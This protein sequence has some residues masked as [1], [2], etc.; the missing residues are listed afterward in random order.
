MSVY[1]SV[2]CHLLQSRT[3]TRKEANSTRDA[4]QVR[5]IPRYKQHSMVTGHVYR[6]EN[7]L[8]GS[9]ACVFSSSLVQTHPCYFD[10]NNPESP[11]NYPPCA[12]GTE[13][14]ESLPSKR[15]MNVKEEGERVKEKRLCL[16]RIINYCSRYQ[17]QG[18]IIELPRLLN[19]KSHT[20]LF[21]L[22]AL[23]AESL[24]LQQNGVVDV[25]T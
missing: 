18:C 15:A 8:F 4:L 22:V 3:S 11:C 13:L 24:Q 14:D 21:E 10:H 23:K 9:G 1:P 17:D 7:D 25:E 6:K 12:N 2:L 16:G 20:E 5:K 19:K